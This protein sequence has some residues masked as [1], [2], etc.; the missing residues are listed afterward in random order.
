MQLHNEE[1]TNQDKVGFFFFTPAWRW[2]CS[3]GICAAR[4]WDRSCSYSSVRSSTVVLSVVKCLQRKDE[5]NIMI[6]KKKHTLLLLGSVSS[7]A[8]ISGRRAELCSSVL[9]LVRNPGRQRN[10]ECRRRG[11]HI[12]LVWKTLLVRHFQRK[13]S[14]ALLSS[15]IMCPMKFE[16]QQAPLSWRG[17][18]HWHCG[19]FNIHPSTGASDSLGLARFQSPQ[20]FPVSFSAPCVFLRG[21]EEKRKEEGSGGV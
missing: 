9:A 15:E 18:H 19:V 17:Q 21:E 8:A 1:E 20:F 3:S 4:V 14:Y 11:S 2:H 13:L 12:H 5:G 6:K 7:R 16:L 10:R